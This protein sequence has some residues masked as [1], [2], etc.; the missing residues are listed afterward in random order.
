MEQYIQLPKK[1][2]K[3]SFGTVALIQRKTDGQVIKQNHFSAPTLLQISY[4]Q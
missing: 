3:G 2:G 1:V 4:S